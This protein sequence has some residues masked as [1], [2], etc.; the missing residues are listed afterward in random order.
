MILYSVLGGVMD[1]AAM[2][3]GGNG[4]WGRTRTEAGARAV[5]QELQARGGR[6]QRSRRQNIVVAC[7]AVTVLVGIAIYL[8]V[9]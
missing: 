5:V 9:S 6:P 1:M 4:Q 3:G 7:V 8:L 2:S